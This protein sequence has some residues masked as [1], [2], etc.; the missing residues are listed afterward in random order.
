MGEIFVRNVNGD[1]RAVEVE[2]SQN[3]ASVKLQIRDIWVIEAEEQRLIYN[4]RKLDDT[5]TLN[6]YG[7]R[8]LDTLHL[9]LVP[10]RRN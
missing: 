5:R 3:I 6:Y 7:I 1:T 8:P 10:R 2:G 9:V 4:G